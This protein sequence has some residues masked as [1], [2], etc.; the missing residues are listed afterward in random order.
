[1]EAATGTW[2]GRFQDPHAIRRRGLLDVYACREVQQLEPRVV[3][4]GSPSADPDQVRAALDAIAQAHARIVSPCIAPVDHRGAI[5]AIE[6][7]SLMCDAVIDLEGVFELLSRTGCKAEHNVGMRLIDHVHDTL[8]VAHE[9]LDPDE[10]PYCLGAICWASVLL[11][12][13][14]QLW[15]MGFGHN[16][17]IR[18][19]PLSITVSPGLCEPPEVSVGIPP[20]PPFAS[21]PEPLQLALSGAAGKWEPLAQIMSDTSNRA[22]SLLPGMRHQTIAELNAEYAQSRA[23]YGVTA[24]EEIMR[25]FFGDCVRSILTKP[26]RP[27]KDHDVRPGRH[28]YGGRYRLDRPLDAGA[29][30]L[31]WLGWDRQLQEPV[32]MKVLRGEGTATRRRRF[33]REVRILRAVNH[34]HL[35]R[36]Y[37]FFEEGGRLVGVMEYVEGDRLDQVSESMTE[38]ELVT[39]GA[40]LLD[41]LA[42]LHEM[43]VVHRDVKPQNILVNGT[44]GGVLVDFGIAGEAQSDLTGTG[45]VGTLGY[46]APEHLAGR[47]VGPPAD[48]YALSTV[49]TEAL[50]GRIDQ[51]PDPWRPHLLRGLNPDPDQRPSAVELAALLRQKTPP[52][53]PPARPRGLRISADHKKFTLPSGEVIDLSRR[54]APR[55]LL[56]YLTLAHARQPGVACSWEELVEAG[57]PG[58]RMTAESGKGRVYVAIYTLRKMGFDEHLVRHDDGY[59]LD[60]HLTIGQ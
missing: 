14:G 48:V 18:P 47:R 24:T 1:M 40:D 23:M 5:G 56:T 39:L 9:T 53:A 20:T 32:A 51:V 10:R 36:G 21:L 55:L 29:T 46:M 57:W 43:G 44:R 42:A 34:P 19:R 37:D 17:P 16:F 49:L 54:R 15:L 2:L 59:L 26:A 52:E 41:G 7:L 12:A 30:S 6:Y 13:N 38:D 50:G 25:G 27:T 35:V 31:V 33:Y 45:P 8:A 22:L 60:P 3:L 28:W 58:E 4:I 11:N